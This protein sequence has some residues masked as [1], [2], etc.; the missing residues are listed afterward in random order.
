MTDVACEVDFNLKLLEVLKKLASIANAQSARFKFKWEEYL[1]PINDKPSLIRKIPQP[2]NEERFCSSA[3]YRIEILKIIENALVDGYYLIKNLV[4]TLYNQYFN[5]SALLQQDF[6]TK[7]QITLKY[8]VAKEILGNL[9]QYNKMDPDT[10]PL[11]YNIIARNYLIIKLQ[12]INLEEIMDN[13]KK[14]NRVVSKED[15]IKAMEEIQE[16]G[17][18]NIE[19]KDDTLFYTLKEPLKL[20]EEGEYNYNLKLRA[21]VEFPT[22]FYRSFYNIRELNVTPSNEMK[23]KDFLMQVLSKAAIQGFPSTH[24]VIKHLIIY[25]EKLKEMEQV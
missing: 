4:S 22:Q 14:L 13:L 1:N 17:L 2:I 15:L 20:S 19:K 23:Y 5:N 21:L 6:I 9:I 24:Y 10:V 7:D 11:K 16:D 3:D 18:L 25:Y 12:G 8:L